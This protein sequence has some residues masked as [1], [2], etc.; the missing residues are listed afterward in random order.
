[1]ATTGGDWLEI[2]V[3]H[4][5]LGEHVFYPKANEGNTFDP[6]GIRTN[7]DAN[8][9]SGD[10]QSIYQMNRVRGFLEVTVANDMNTRQDFIFAKNLG[11]SPVEASY[12]ASHI[13]GSTWGFNG[14]PVGDIQVDSNASTFTLKV[15]FSGDPNKLT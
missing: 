13:N 12:V 14:K 5:T 9:V 11:A 7:D 8:Q 3:S 10:G 6:G 1:M 15:A 4:P 2:R